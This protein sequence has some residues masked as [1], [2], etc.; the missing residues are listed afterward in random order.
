MAGRY[1]VDESIDVQGEKDNSKYAL[2]IFTGI[3][4]IKNI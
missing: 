1:D 4:T 2:N 3:Q